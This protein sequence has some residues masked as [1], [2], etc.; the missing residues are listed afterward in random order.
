MSPL[1]AIS[2]EP[3]VFT[4]TEGF[5]VGLAGG[6]C[7]TNRFDIYLGIYTPTL[8][9]FTGFYFGTLCAKLFRG[10]QAPGVVC[11]DARI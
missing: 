8:G 7:R 10:T 3:K 9:W 11:S 1:S 4:T 2:K 5:P 6:H